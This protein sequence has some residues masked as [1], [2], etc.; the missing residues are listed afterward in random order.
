MHPLSQ[1]ANSYQVSA[2]LGSEDSVF[3]TFVA[4]ES[5]DFPRTGSLINITGVDT[6]TVIYKVP[7]PYPLYI[8]I[9]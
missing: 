2:E 7:A 9:N 3:T 6:V 8:K 1:E 4:D 5:A